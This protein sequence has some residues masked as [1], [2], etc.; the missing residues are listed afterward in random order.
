MIIMRTQYKE[1]IFAV[2]AA[3]LSIPTKEY[4]DFLS[5]ILLGAALIMIVKT[6]FQLLKKKTS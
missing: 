6:G 5:G 4:S 3:L 2:I 1:M